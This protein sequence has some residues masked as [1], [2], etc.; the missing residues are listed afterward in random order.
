MCARVLNFMTSV[1]SAEA[2]SFLVKRKARVA[3]RSKRSGAIA[4]MTAGKQTHHSHLRA[5]CHEI[6]R[7][8]MLAFA[9]LSG[10]NSRYF[11][12]GQY[13]D[14]MLTFC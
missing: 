7:S 4:P 2:G 9:K 8:L 12:P 6:A 5:V 3:S 1:V 14:I 13:M 11:K 10:D